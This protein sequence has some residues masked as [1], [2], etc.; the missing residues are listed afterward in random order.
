MK[1]KIKALVLL[2][3]TGFCTILNGSQLSAQVVSKGSSQ[4]FIGYGAPNF[5]AVILGVAS[6]GSAILGAV[7]TTA[8]AGAVTESDNLT[9]MGPYTFCYQY[10][11]VNRLAVGLQLGY[12]SASDEIKWQYND[13]LLG[14]FNYSY[15]LKLSMFTAMV[16]I[17]YH[18]L[19]SSRADLYSGAAGGYGS[20]KYSITGNEDPG[21]PKQ[22]TVGGFTW[23]VNLIGFRYL[24]GGNIGAFGELGLG[25]MGLATIGISAKLGDHK[26]G[27]WQKHNNGGWQKPGR[28]RYN[29]SFN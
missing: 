21:G 29:D 6:W 25:Y 10:A 18:Y 24:I 22:Q 4:I 15:S 17:D 5:P 19:K 23:A 9:S 28:A 27:G 12:T 20:I 1:N 26:A 14:T 3:A 2:A 8:T 13:P 7:G 11:P 16:K